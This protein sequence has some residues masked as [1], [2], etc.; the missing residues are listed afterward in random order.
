MKVILSEFQDNLGYV[1][2]WGRKIA[3]KQPPTIKV[4]GS[5]KGHS[6][7]LLSIVYISPVLS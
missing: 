4:K 7:K 3:T 6:F 2:S 5:E 1:R